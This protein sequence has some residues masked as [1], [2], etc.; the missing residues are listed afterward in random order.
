MNWKCCSTNNKSDNLEANAYSGRF[1]FFGGDMS[2]NVKCVLIA[3]NSILVVFLLL[4]GCAFYYF[5]ASDVQYIVNFIN[6]NPEKVS[7]ILVENGEEVISISENNKMPLASV[8]KIMIAIEF[9]KQVEK[10]I[11]NPK[12][13]IPLKKLEDYVLIKREN[14]NHKKWLNKIKTIKGE[15]AKTIQLEEIVRSLFTHSSN[16]NTDYL[17][18]KLGLENVN[19]TIAKNYKPHD[20][21]YPISLSELTHHYIKW[22][23]KDFTS[24]ETNDRITKLNYEEYTHLITS[25]QKLIE[26]GKYPNYKNYQPTLEEQETMTRYLPKASAKVYSDLLGHINKDKFKYKKELLRLLAIKTNKEMYIGGKDGRTLNIINKTIFAKDKEGN[27]T[28]IVFFTKDLDYE[29]YQK[30]DHNIDEFIQ[31]L[32][33][34]ELYLNAE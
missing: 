21:L 7:F 33:D 17:L 6:E 31:K 28:E 19:N 10:G 27:T 13:Q 26:Q 1:F 8:Y 16:P 11:I 3:I 24:K 5:K 32:L 2:K 4:A 20:K 25:I 18:D 34:K 23:Y 14:D 9:I 29:E 22:K 15:K 30:I 12:E